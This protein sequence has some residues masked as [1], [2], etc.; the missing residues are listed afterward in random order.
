MAIFF[1]IFPVFVLTKNDTIS[2]LEKLGCGVEAMTVCVTCLSPTVLLPVLLSSLHTFP[3]GSHQIGQGR[4]PPSL[5]LVLPEVFATI[6]YSL[7]RL[8]EVP[9]VTSRYSHNQLR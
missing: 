8:Q 5:S 4:W 3:Y 6:V 1:L 7:L 9:S 2:F